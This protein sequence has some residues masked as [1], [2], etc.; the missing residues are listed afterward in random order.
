VILEQLD[1]TAEE[2]GATTGW[3]VT[4]EG[5]CKGELCVPLG[6]ATTEG[7]DLVA[8]AERLGMPLVEDAGS[9][10]W[11]LGPETI[12]G[13]ALSTAQAP[14][15]VL[16]DLD[17]S[18][19]RLS[20][21]RGQKVVLVAW[22]PY[23]GCSF[24]LPGWQALRA[25][26]HPRG[27]EIVTVC[28]EVTGAGTAR[29]LIEAARPEHPS[30]I[31][32]AHEMDVAFGVVNIPNGIWIDERGVIVRPAEP[33]WSGFPREVPGAKG[34]ARLSEVAS[35]I[36]IDSGSYAAAIRDWAEHGSASRWVLPPDEVV[37][38]SHP[39]PAAVAEAAAHFELGQHL[40]RAGQRDDAIAHFRDA[41]RLQPDNWTYKRQAWSLVSAEGDPGPRG[42]FVQGPV[43][44][45]EED[46][47]FDSD[48]ASDVLKLSPGEY[49]P[50]MT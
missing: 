40:W 47:P 43:D 14:E 4:P 8:V 48:F 18:P 7:F 12:G 24:D 35:R 23:C 41:H 22:A 17:G 29:P 2:F 38:R 33:A 10:V 36:K 21:L 45:R 44:G 16:P 11:A 13:R 5:A 31:D 39:R 9:G 15:L 30:L 37:A 1:V 26:V 27:V 3:T 32:V 20:S 25:E 28:L 46:W 34:D 42:R 49:Y 6:A 19:F 50:E